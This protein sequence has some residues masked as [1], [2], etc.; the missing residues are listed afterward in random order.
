MDEAVA[1]RARH[2]WIDFGDDHAR[3][4]EDRGRE[5]HRH[6]EADKATSIRRGN[7]EQRHVDRQPS[8]R[9]KTRHLL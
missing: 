9:Q 2:L 3:N 7:L 5:V 1:V 6:P 8:A 4:A